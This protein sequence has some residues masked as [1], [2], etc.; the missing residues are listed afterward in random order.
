VAE[1]YCNEDQLRMTLELKFN[2]SS[3]K[4][5]ILYKYSV[6]VVRSLVSSNRE[7]AMT[8]Q[9]EADTR[10]LVN[11]IAGAAEIDGSAPGDNF[12]ILQPNDSYTTKAHVILFLNR[13]EKGVPRNLSPGDHYLQV[14][15]QTWYL[16]DDLSKKLSKQWRPTGSLWTDDVRSQ[17]MR[18]RIESK[19]SVGKCSQ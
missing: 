18:F 5:I 1:E 8:K 19:D 2:N 16:S 14:V 11:L 9:Y 17:P 3:Q 7:S 15:V 12:A 4:R 10:Y 6:G 13:V